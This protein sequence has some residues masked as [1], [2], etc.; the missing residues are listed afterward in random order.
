MTLF[1]PKCFLSLLLLGA[2]PSV[3]A[4]IQTCPDPLT[5]LLSKGEIPFPWLQ[6]PFSHKVIKSNITT[7]FVSATVLVAGLGR[8]VLCTY[9]NSLND[10]S[11]W[12]P[13]LTKIP[14]SV[15][16]R[17]I[18]NVGGYICSFSREE[19]RFTVVEK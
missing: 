17:W 13:V 8:G 1:R 4:S 19:C 15:D 11:I 9:T 10:Y 14:A 6:N 5:G 2:L 12:W 16:Y 18:E 7:R 3:H